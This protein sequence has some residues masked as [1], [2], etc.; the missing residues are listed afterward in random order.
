[1]EPERSILGAAGGVI[2]PKSKLLFPKEHGLSKPRPPRQACRSPDR[3]ARHPSSRSAASARR[4]RCG[5]CLPC[6]RRLAKKASAA[7][8]RASGRSCANCQLFLAGVVRKKLGYPTTRLAQCPGHAPC[9]RIGEGGPL[10]LGRCD[11]SKRT[12]NVPPHLRHGATAS[13]V[14]LMT[15][16]GFFQIGVPP[17][18]CESVARARAN[19]S[20]RL[21]IALIV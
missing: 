5:I 10:R 8:K 20:G 13:P 15:L 9:A 17:R 1:M 12:H 21:Y 2:S 19:S 3:R 11:R 16:A 4:D 14:R 7:T 18:P 6:A